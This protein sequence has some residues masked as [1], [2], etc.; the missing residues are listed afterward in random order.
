MKTETL[1]L[2][3][4]C[5]VPQSLICLNPQFTTGTAACGGYGTQ[6]VGYLMYSL[7]ASR[8]GYNLAPLN[9]YS[10]FPF[11]TEQVCS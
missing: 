11:A 7:Q 4:E 6:E 5:E 1:L 10:C 2:Y 9:G 3:L 8:G